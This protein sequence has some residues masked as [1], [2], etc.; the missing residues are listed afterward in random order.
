MQLPTAALMR[1]G[2][3]IPIPSQPLSPGLALAWQLLLIPAEEGSKSPARQAEFPSS[4]ST[5]LTLHRSPL[6]SH[7]PRGIHTLLLT[8]PHCSAWAES[9]Q[10]LLT[11]GGGS[12]ELPLAGWPQGDNTSP[13]E[14]W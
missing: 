7:T 13:A 14:P 9:G 10:M 12:V 3:P 6:V 4:L 11:E 1:I 5:S 2:I 8:I